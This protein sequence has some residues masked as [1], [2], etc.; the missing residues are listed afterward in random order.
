[1]SAQDRIRGCIVGGVIGDAFGAPLEGASQIG[2]SKLVARRAVTPEPWGYTDDGAMLL[3]CAEALVSER[4]VEPT[5]LLRALQARYEPAR[6]FGHGMKL[7]LEAFE[8]G[9]SWDR[10][11]F[12]A[13]P[14]GSHGNGG[15]VRISPIAVARWP[16]PEELDRAVWLA[17][18]VTHAHP[19]AIAFARLQAAAIAIVLSDPN[20]VA[21]TGAFHAA[22]TARLHPI[23]AEVRHKLDLVLELV[24]AAATPQVAARE[25]GTSTAARESVPAALWSFLSEH[26]SFS[27]AV[28]AAALLGGDVDSICCLVGAMHGFAAIDQL[29]IANLANE[30]PA[31]EKM[32]ELADRL[33]AMQPIAVRRDWS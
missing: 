7:A 9:S 6:G 21:A 14:A 13:W 8:L 22:I 4:T 12:A 19:E 28:S 20:I 17:T 11:A 23:P 10:C 33:H 3:A 16:S 2:L 32:V 27:R 29:W 5:A 24:A 15:A 18:R 25:L 1:M 31:L 26:A 30:Q